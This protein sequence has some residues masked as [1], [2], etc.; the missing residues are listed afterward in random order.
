[1]FRG[2]RIDLAGGRVKGGGGRSKRDRGEGTGRDG[3]RGSTKNINRVYLFA[4]ECV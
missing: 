3:G 2:N 4:R 1:M